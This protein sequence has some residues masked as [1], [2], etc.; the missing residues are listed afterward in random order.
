MMLKDT[1]IIIAII[2]GFIGLV[3]NLY[4][5]FRF[6]N[7]METNSIIYQKEM[8]ELKQ[9][10]QKE[11]AEIKDMHQTE[12]REFKSMLFESD[13]KPKFIRAEYC[14]KNREAISSMIEKSFTLL[15]YELMEAIEGKTNKTTQRIHEKIESVEREVKELKEKN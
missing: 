10:R 12:L 3:T 14:V 6:M 9:T 8:A 13:G 7:R 11:M 1:Q 15:K 4:Y 2:A 5:L